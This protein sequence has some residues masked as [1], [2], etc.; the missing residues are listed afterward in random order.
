MSHARSS[1]GFA[2]TIVALLA[3]GC[4][5][6][7]AQEENFTPPQAYPV[8]RYEAGW[9]KNPF[10]LKTAPVALERTSALQDLAIGSLFGLRSDPI[11]VVVNTKTGARTRLKTGETA[12]NGMLLKSVSVQETQKDT[13]AEVAMNGETAVLKF[14]YDFYRQN[15]TPA[16]DARHRAGENPA[17]RDGA[18]IPGPPG[19]MPPDR[20]G[21]PARGGG[22]P[23]PAN[24]SKSGRA[25]IFNNPA[26]Q[27]NMP[28]GAPSRPPEPRPT[29]G[30]RMLNTAPT[31]APP[32][33]IR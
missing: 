25:S 14:D 15:A 19:A 27:R 2:A 6:A 1:T 28:P 12:Q 33:R 16:N 21:S 30:G 8:D 26:V 10:T 29:P 17:V 24:A 9:N 18:P 4:Q 3:M 22:V 20:T 11:V 31:G 32:T 5:I 7:I 23:D 13:S